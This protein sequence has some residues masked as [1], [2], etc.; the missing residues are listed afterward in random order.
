M[1][2]IIMVLLSLVSMS[3]L[4]YALNESELNPWTM[5]ASFGMVTY[6]NMMNDDG[7]TAIG[8]L[9]LGHMLLTKPSWQAG[10]EAG[11]QS[12]NTMRLNLP[13]ESIDTLG[14]VPLEVKIKPLL[15]VLVSFKTEPLTSF[16]IVAWLKGGAAY[17]QLQLDHE[18]VNDLNEFSPEIQMG[19]GYRINELATFNIGYQIIWSKQ[20][21]LNV[22]P[23]AET[24]VLHYIPTQQSLLIGFSFNFL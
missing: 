14:G 5:E 2:K 15:D 7:Q 23:Q 20:T 10:I 8:R 16:P 1:K 17:R 6:P 12:G 3:G 22:N 21:M 24:G 11:I 9:S 4:T 18:S 19:F 13:K